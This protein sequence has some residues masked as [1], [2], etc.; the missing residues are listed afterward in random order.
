VPEKGGPP[1]KG[2][3][4]A[5][6]AGPYVPE[7]AG[8]SELRR[9]AGGCQGCPLFREATQTVF[10]SGDASARAVLVGEAR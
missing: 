9:A 1:E 3:P 4:E 2:D 8:L 7:D 10:G 5:Y 6:D